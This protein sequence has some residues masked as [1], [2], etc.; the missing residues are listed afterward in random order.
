[1]RRV[2]EFWQREYLDRYVRNAEHFEKVLAYIEDNP[3]TA[4]LAK[5]KTEWLWSSAKFRNPGS[6]GVPP[7]SC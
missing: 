5:L 6:A 3:V 1:M 4:G 2:G 7:A